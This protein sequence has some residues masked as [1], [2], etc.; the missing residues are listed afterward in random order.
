MSDIA[1]LHNARA[2]S[3]YSPTGRAQRP[4]TTPT[5][6]TRGSDQLE[7]SETAKL[8]AKL[9]NLPDVRED[10]VARVKAEIADG[11]YETADKLDAAIE[12]LAEHLANE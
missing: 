1:P 9:A 7:L 11:T 12:G 6:Y 4:A 8:L 2:A 3:S 5:E 10:L